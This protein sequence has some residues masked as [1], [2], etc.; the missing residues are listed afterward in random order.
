MKY[1][2]RSSSG[3]DTLMLVT[4]R[5]VTNAWGL[6][7]FSCNPSSKEPPGNLCR[8]YFAA[9]KNEKEGEFCMCGWERCQRAGFRYGVGK[10][11]LEEGETEG[12]GELIENQVVFLRGF[13]IALRKP[14]DEC[15]IGRGNK[16]YQTSNWA[17]NQGSEGQSG[18]GWDWGWKSWLWSCFFSSP[19]AVNDEKRINSSTDSVASSTTPVSLELEEPEII[20]DFMGGMP[21]VCGLL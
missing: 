10:R 18:W 13:G 9:G 6:A 12:E 7:T 4:G 1:R 19:S 14:D 5:T 3:L 11:C 21:E 16:K 20:I 2:G 8:A 17:R 15:A